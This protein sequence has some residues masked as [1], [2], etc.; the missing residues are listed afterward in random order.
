MVKSGDPGHRLYRLGRGFRS[1]S[2]QPTKTA[3]TVFLNA[4]IR[5]CLITK[6]CLI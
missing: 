1:G 3:N 5:E 6:L 2:I 4:E